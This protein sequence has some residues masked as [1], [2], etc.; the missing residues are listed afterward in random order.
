MPL[1]RITAISCSILLLTIAPASPEPSAQPKFKSSELQ[2]TVN[3]AK[4]NAAAQ[5]VISLLFE[6][7][8]R[9]NVALYGVEGTGVTTE[10]G[11]T[12]E[13]TGVIGLPLCAASCENPVAAVG[14]HVDPVM[15]EKD[16]S[17]LATYVFAGEASKDECS[18]DLAVRIYLARLGNGTQPAYTHKWRQL[19]IG[20]ANVTLC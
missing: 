12:A 4:R 6:N 15:I 16:G 7:V 3:R 1:S 18:L 17:L 2:V 20:L 8:S 13:P 19:S 11:E 5:L 9:E 14:V 10:A